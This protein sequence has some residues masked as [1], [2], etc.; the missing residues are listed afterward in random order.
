MLLPVGQPGSTLFHV[1]LNA[2][3][4]AHRR[5]RASSLHWI[6]E[7]RA[8]RAL[9]VKFAGSNPIVA[10]GN[11]IFNGDGNMTLARFETTVDDAISTPT[12]G[13]S[14]SPRMRWLR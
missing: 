3:L 12:P 1:S 8:E 2:S 5:D 10:A 9:G 14:P 4:Y 11:Q 13:P 7:S 6:G